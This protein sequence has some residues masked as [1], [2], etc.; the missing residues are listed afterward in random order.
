M[1]PDHARWQRCWSRHCCLFIHTCWRRCTPLKGRGV[2]SLALALFSHAAEGQGHVG[3]DHAPQGLVVQRLHHPA[4]DEALTGGR[5]QYNR[6]LEPWWEVPAPRAGR[7]S[8]HAQAAE[9]NSGR[10]QH[11]Q[12]GKVHGMPPRRTPRRH[13]QSS[14]SS[15]NGSPAVPKTTVSTFM[16]ANA[17]AVGSAPTYDQAAARMQVTRLKCECHAQA[18]HCPTCTLVVR[19]QSRPG[20]ATNASGYKPTS[21]IHLRPRGTPAAGAR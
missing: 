6:S 18:A 12:Q 17:G 2:C 7:H 8:S 5:E 21:S 19:L 1:G 14:F 11:A 4:G 13:T 3:L 9:S 10:A 15:S 20:H 16:H